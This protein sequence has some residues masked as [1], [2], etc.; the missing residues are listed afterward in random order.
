MAEYYSAELAEKLII[1]HSCTEISYGLF[2]YM[3]FDCDY[4]FG[5]KGNSYSSG[6]KVGCVLSE[7]EEPPSDLEELPPDSPPPCDCEEAPPS[8]S[9]S[10]FCDPES[11]PPLLSS[12]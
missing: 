11:E 5:I 12:D 1:A 2:C 6:T 8:E 10:F 9:G 3:R 4:S 7:S